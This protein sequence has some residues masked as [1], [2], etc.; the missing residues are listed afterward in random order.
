MIEVLFLLLW[1]GLFCGAGYLSWIKIARHLKVYLMMFYN[2]AYLIGV[3][4]L[5]PRLGEMWR[6]F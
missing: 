5:Y 3:F 2:C 1:T 6:F 4:L